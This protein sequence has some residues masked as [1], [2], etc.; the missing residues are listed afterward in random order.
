MK[1]YTYEDFASGGILMLNDDP[2]RAVNICQ[3]AFP[4]C[5]KASGT[6]LIYF[7]GLGSEDSFVWLSGHLL[8]DFPKNTLAV[9]ASQISLEP[10]EKEYVNNLKRTPMVEHTGKADRKIIGVVIPFD[11]KQWDVKKGHIAT[12]IN[13]KTF[14]TGTGVWVPEEICRDWER[15]YEEQPEEKN[16]IV[17][18]QIGDNNVIQ[19]CVPKEYIK[20]IQLMLVPFVGIAGCVHPKP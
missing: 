8:G 17:S 13:P 6:D 11:V 10:R 1:N 16:S 12:Y 5:L 14:L 3:L 19:Y 7:K 18:I 9:P 4:E 2:E 20:K 15:V